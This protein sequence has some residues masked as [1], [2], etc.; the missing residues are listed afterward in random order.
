MGFSMFESVCFHTLLSGW[1][2]RSWS[3]IQNTDRQLV[4]SSHAVSAGEEWVLGRSSWLRIISSTTLM[5]SSV[6]TDLDHPQ[7]S[8]QATSQVLS[9]FFNSFF[10]PFMFHSCF[11]WS[12]T[13]FVALH[14]YFIWRYLIIT[15]SWYENT[16]SPVAN[17]LI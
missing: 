8:F 3:I 2:S 15:L 4:L 9:N 10:T 1:R 12:L 11:G 5:F 16:I 17:N 13:I 6:H 14:L 7:P